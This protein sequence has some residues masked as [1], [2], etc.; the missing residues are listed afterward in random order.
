MTSH[1]H[2]LKMILSV[3]QPVIVG[4]HT[5]LCLCFIS[6]ASS[7]H[8]TPLC[9]IQMSKAENERRR[10]AAILD[11]WLGVEMARGRGRGECGLKRFCGR[12]LNKQRPEPR[13]FFIHGEVRRSAPCVRRHCCGYNGWQRQH[14]NKTRQS[15][16]G[17]RWAA[18]WLA[19]NNCLL[20]KAP[21]TRLSDPSS[22]S[23]KRTL[24]TG[25]S[26]FWKHG[27]SPRREANH[28]I[29]AGRRRYQGAAPAALLRRAGNLGAANICW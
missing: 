14:V 2:A 11:Y 9:P 20:L 6:V 7:C 5:I 28:V 1:S 18:G 21:A 27:L 16:S 15:P 17:K 26:S 12:C 23:T 22:T 19:V 13:V 24:K 3:Q 29:S 8:R 25:F 4:I 10:C